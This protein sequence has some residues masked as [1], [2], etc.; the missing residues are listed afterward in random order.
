MTFGVWKKIRIY[1]SNFLLL[2]RLPEY[3]WKVSD[4]RP[5]F[6]KWL[7][8]GSSTSKQCDSPSNKNSG[9]FFCLTYVQWN[10]WEI[11]LLRILCT[12]PL[13][14]GTR[15]KPAGWFRPQRKVI[16]TNCDLSFFVIKFRIIDFIGPTPW[17]NSLNA[18]RPSFHTPELSPEKNKLPHIDRHVRALE[19]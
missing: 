10:S 13:N 8:R 7:F 17:E 19:Q 14:R 11:L 15:S 18:W 6:P 3:N 2:Q 5:P 1:V 12:S 16:L 4:R 9:R